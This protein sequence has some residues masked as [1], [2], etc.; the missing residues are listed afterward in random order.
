MEKPARMF[1]RDHEW[2]TLTRFA[3][4]DQPGAM[5]GVVSGRRRQGKTFL[6]DALCRATGGFYFGAV[7]ETET[8]SLRRIGTALTD[9]LNLPVPFRPTDWY[10]V[11]DALLALGRERPVPVVLDEFPYLVKAS[12][13]LPSIIQQAYGPLRDE[14]VES[15]TRLLL[16]GSAL[17]VM[18]GLLSGNAPLRGRASLELVV[19]TLDHRLSEQFWGIT[20]HR[21]AVQVNSVVGGTP[22][23][24]RELARND[25]P[26]G[27]EDFDDWVVR[28]VLSAESP[29]FREARYLLAE[30]PDLRDSALYHAVLAGVAAGNASRGGIANYLG[31]KSS[32]LA[33]PLDVLEDAGLLVRDADVFRDKRST[34][35]I[36]EPLITFYH[37]VMRPVWDQL[38]R[39]GFAQRVWDGSQRRFVSNV[40]GPRFEEICREW[41]LFYADDGVFGEL[42]ARVG[43]GVVSDPGQRTT[44]EVDVAVIGTGDR[45]KP[46]LLAI[47]EVKWGD[48]MGVGHLE[49]LRHVASVLR[50]NDRYDTSRIRLLCFSA[51][52]FMPELHDAERAGD[53]VLVGLDRLYN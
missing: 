52:G 10:E 34:Y 23:Y 30:E 28:T 24:R 39:P 38:E 13:A 29:L 25:V 17:S 5:L 15:R 41:A 2:S 12:P 36:A 3:V 14:R 31:R 32:D 45:G 1:D 48:V 49:R 35:R 9:F 8:E 4:D 21:L 22:A 51:A 18:G 43:H 20:D 50:R 37:A 27:L 11:V 6:L 26:A 42:P 40:L 44:H 46:P 53:V 7:E 19:R 16:C 33:H 47:G